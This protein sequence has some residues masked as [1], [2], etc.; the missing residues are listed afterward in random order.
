[1]VISASFNMANLIL[2]EATLSFLGLGVQAPTPSWGGMIMDGAH[3][4]RVAPWLLFPP[5]LMIFFSIF[6]Y[7]IL[8]QYLKARFRSPADN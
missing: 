7:D 1:M 3:S 5:A 4:I 6:S 2:V 8:S